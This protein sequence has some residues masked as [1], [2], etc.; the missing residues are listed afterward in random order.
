M[1]P[2]LP[3]HV[4]LALSNGVTTAPLRGGSAVSFPFHTHIKAFSLENLR[5]CKNPK[6][7]CREGIVFSN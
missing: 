1:R 6:N 2:W 7:P 4:E 3:P 5:I